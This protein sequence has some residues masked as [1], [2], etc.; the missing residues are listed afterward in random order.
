MI[1]WVKDLALSLL[2]HRFDP[3]PGNFHVPQREPKKPQNTLPTGCGTISGVLGRGRCVLRWGP[4]TRTH[5]PPR[6]PPGA[7][8]G[9]DIRGVAGTRAYSWA[10]PRC[11]IP[12]CAFHEPGTE[13]GHCGHQAEMMKNGGRG[14]S[15]GDSGP[16]RRPWGA[17][18]KATTM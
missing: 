8:V 7:R 3:W 2:W 13:W 6:L 15:G 17:P 12:M 18:T 11:S 5:E 10:S 9:Q 4:C 14:R 1:Q 16:W